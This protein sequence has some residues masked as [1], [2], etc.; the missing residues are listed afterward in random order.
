MVRAL[1]TVFCAT[2]KE[3]T[4][5]NS[6]DAAE[7][8]RYVELSQKLLSCLSIIVDIVISDDFL[9]KLKEMDPIQR[10]D[11]LGMILLNQKI[12]V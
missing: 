7:S 10:Q 4:A 11:C 5:I 2:C 3:N 12:L 6:L 9:V 8:D 1:R